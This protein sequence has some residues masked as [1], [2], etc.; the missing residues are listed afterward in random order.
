MILDSNIIDQVIEILN[1]LKKGPDSGKSKSKSRGLS[2]R[3]KS[4]LFEWLLHSLDFAYIYLT[5]NYEYSY[6]AFNS[7]RPISSFAV[8]TS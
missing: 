6:F 7:A 5:N 2:V 3:K 4:L 8:C 1:T